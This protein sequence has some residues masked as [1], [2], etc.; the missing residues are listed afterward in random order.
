MSTTALATPD[1][2]S[3]KEDAAL[4]VSLDQVADEFA[5]LERLVP[6]LDKLAARQR[7]LQRVIKAV[8]GDG[9]IGT[10]SGV[11]VVS[12]RKTLRVGVSQKLLKEKYPHIV[13][14]VLD[15][16]EVRRFLVLDR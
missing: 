9:E 16:A 8:M 7:S 15:I 4:L 13:P 6:R 12:W 10:V 14:E 1:P 2:E 11:P 5:Q 3:G